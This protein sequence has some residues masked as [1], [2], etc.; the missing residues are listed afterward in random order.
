MHVY[1]GEAVSVFDGRRRYDFVMEPGGAETLSPSDYSPFAG[2]AT[3]CNARMIRIKG[4]QE[5]PHEPDRWGDYKRQAR[6]WVAPVFEGVLP[7]P[8]RIEIDTPFGAIRAH[9]ADA[10]LDRGG[11][12]QSL[13]RAAHPASPKPA[14]KHILAGA[15]GAKI[16]APENVLNP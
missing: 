11:T 1:D 15:G 8:V 2:A 6:V 12:K 14:V 4:F 5:Y 9:L 10:R 3:I 7:A 13:A 16:P